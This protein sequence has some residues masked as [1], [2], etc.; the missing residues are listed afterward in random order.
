[1]DNL[2]KAYPFTAQQNQFTRDTAYL[3]RTELR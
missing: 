2:H 3:D 1:M